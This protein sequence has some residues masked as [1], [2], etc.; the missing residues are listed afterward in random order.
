MDAEKVVT[1]SLDSAFDRAQAATVVTDV[2]DTDEAMKAFTILKG[3]GLQ[4]DEV[5][6]KRLLRKIDMIL[7]PV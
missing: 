5:T 1:S 7:M 2:S 6:N 4:L 3:E